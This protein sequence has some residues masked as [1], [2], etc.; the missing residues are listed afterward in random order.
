M[1]KASPKSPRK[2]PHLPAPANGRQDN[3]VEAPV[4]RSKSSNA[5]NPN[6]PP[7]NH[8]TSLYP[9]AVGSLLQRHPNC[10]APGWTGGWRG[11]MNLTN[12]MH[13]YA[14]LPPS[15]FGVVQLSSFGAVSRFQGRDRQCGDAAILK[16]NPPG[17]AATPSAELQLHAGW[18]SHDVR[19]PHS[20]HPWQGAELG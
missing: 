6:L 2:A 13:H 7:P 20:A 14:R 3:D 19:V 15:E 8:L 12:I 11:E 17:P 10:C 1:P 16:E 18:P 9:T 4:L 5:K